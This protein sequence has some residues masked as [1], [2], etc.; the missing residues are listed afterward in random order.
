MFLCPVPFAC[1][2]KDTVRRG[3]AVD[4]IVRTFVLRVEASCVFVRVFA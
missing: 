2:F 4:F 3:V 1:V